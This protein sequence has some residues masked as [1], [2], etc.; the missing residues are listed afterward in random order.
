[1]PSSAT[2]PQPSTARDY[3][4]FRPIDPILGKLEQTCKS[5]DG[6]TARCPA[7]DD[8]KN[9]LSIREAD[10]G[11]VL[12]KCFAGCSTDS[13]VSALGLTMADLFEPR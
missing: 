12:L 7:H 3:A 4:I 10:D 11:K 1:M 6:W 2:S 8:K 5:S 9:S 13:I